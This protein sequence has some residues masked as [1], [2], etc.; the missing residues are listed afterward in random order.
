MLTKWVLIH[1]NT[2]DLVVLHVVTVDHLLEAI[3]LQDIDQLLEYCADVVGNQLGVWVKFLYWQC[4][5]P[6][7]SP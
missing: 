7:G 2:K 5:R 4:L 3:F 1:P 6:W